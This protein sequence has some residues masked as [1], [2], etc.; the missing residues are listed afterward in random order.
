[1]HF[2]LMCSSARCLN[3]LCPFLGS[4]VRAAEHHWRLSVLLWYCKHSFSNAFTFKTVLPSPKAHV[5][6]VYYSHKEVTLCELCI[7]CV[8][9]ISVSILNELWECYNQCS[10]SLCTTFTL[11]L[12]SLQIYFKFSVYDK[13]SLVG[14]FL[15]ILHC[16]AFFFL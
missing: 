7:S 13:W 8:S 12:V 11:A 6:L 9:V 16:K 15:I 14:C 4:C 1:M 5:C 10:L 2:H 3:S